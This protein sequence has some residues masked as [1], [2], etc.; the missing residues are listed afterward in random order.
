MITRL[1]TGVTRILPGRS[2]WDDIRSAPLRDLM[3]GVTVAVVALPLALGFGIASGFGAAAGM[4]T[5]VVAG[6]VAA[7]FGGSNLQVSGPTGAMTVVIIPTVVELGIGGVLAAGFGAGVLLVALALAR[8]G[9]YVRYLPT[10]VIEGFTIGIAVV[11]FLQ[12]LPIA[13]GVVPQGQHVLATAWHSAVTFGRHPNW[14]EVGVAVATMAFIIIGSKWRP[15]LPF[16]LLAVVIATAAVA[17]TELPVAPIGSLPVGLPAPSW[18]SLRFGD[19]AGVLNAA[20]TMAIL[21]ALEALLSATVADRMRGDGRRHDPDRELFGQGLANMATPLFG[22]VPASAAITRTAVNVR[23]GAVSR[24]AAIWHGLL[25]AVLML[26]AAPL[27]AK[28]PLSALAAVLLATAVR[29][30]EL[31]SIVTL[32]KTTRADAAIVVITV[33]ATVTLDLII[34]VLVGLAASGVVA[35]SKIAGSVRLHRSPIEADDHHDDKAAVLADHIAAYR[36]TGPLFFAAAHRALLELSDV[37]G[38]RVVILQMDQMSTVDASGALALRD[39]VGDLARRNI[40]VYLA[41]VR[42]EHHGTINGLR[43]LGEG[44]HQRAFG[45]TSEAMTAARSRLRLAG[46]L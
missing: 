32:A 15:R 41:G 19:T 17:I 29:M 23:C 39:V 30:I 6:V 18:D 3:S 31:K 27:V 42:H 14:T 13:L 33:I 38:V 43:V 20:V 28:I 1:A 24:M 46:V 9:R 40:E 25:L 37:D 7:A 45:T 11:I 5:A 12:Q 26:A 35:L 4:V 34:A 8:A 22:G 2:D 16:S 21:V 44:S 36:L 10:P